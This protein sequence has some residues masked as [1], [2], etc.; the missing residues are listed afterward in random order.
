LSIEMS[1]FLMLK[2]LCY[3]FEIPLSLIF[4]LARLTID[5]SE[6]RKLP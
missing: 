2:K 4:N 1:D 3:Y 5:E 6:L